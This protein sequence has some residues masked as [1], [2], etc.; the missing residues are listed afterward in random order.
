MND[1]IPEKLEKVRNLDRIEILGKSEKVCQNSDFIL[2]SIKP[3]DFKE[4]FE[5]IKSVDFSEKVII[6]PITGIKIR[7][8]EKLKNSKNIARIMPNLPCYISK[9]SIGVAYS[10]DFDTEKKDL[11]LNILREF[12]KVIEFD[13][14][15]F[16]ALTSFVGSAPGIIFL[17]IESLIDSGIRLGFSY[18]QSKEL[19]LQNLIGSSKMIEAMNKEPS[20]L[21]RMVC[22]PAGTTIEAIY[23]L[24]KNGIRGELMEAF[25]KAFEK[26]KNFEKEV[27][28]E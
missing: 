19:T 15:N 14:E 17:L 7:S 23:Y 2:L 6:S 25:F 26:A 21:K 18:E 12:G 10:K 9:G 20:E 8:L 4:L 3:Q 22:S 11:L 27:D 5:R 24:E 28:A 1:K 13:E 16:S